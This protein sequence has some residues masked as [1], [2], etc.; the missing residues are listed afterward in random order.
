MKSVESYINIYGEMY[1]HLIEDALS[2][3]QQR[4]DRWGLKF[5]EA[6]EQAYVADLVSR[7][8]NV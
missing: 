3:L 5:N 8:A 7:V 1:R 6:E 4:E 2:W